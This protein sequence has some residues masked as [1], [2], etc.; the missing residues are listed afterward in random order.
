MINSIW[1]LETKG[2]NIF[3]LLFQ[4]GAG[5]R[6]V[7]HFM[8]YGWREENYVADFN[9]VFETSRQK[10]LLNKLKHKRRVWELEAVL[11]YKRKGQWAAVVTVEE[12]TSASFVSH[13]LLSTHPLRK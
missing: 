11:A 6:E 10:Q 12:E 1:Y 9:V 13:R 4:W 3:R 5:R 2:I 7:L 8:G